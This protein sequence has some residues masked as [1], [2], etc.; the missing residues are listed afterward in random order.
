M[1]EYFGDGDYWTDC[2]AWVTRG[3]WIETKTL[4]SASSFEV[5]SEVYDTGSIRWFSPNIT[6]LPVNTTSDN[7]F[8]TEVKF[9]DDNVTYTSYMSPTAYKARYFQTRVTVTNTA[10]DIT[11]EGVAAIINIPNYDTV[12]VP[13]TGLDTSTLGGTTSARTYD[14]SDYFSNVLAMTAV[15][16]TGE[17]VLPQLTS[18]TSTATFSLIDL[19]TFSKTAIDDTIN[20]TVTGF[21]KLDTDTS[22]GN[23]TAVI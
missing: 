21:P 4:P 16:T 8:T 17:L 22:T 5:E 11:N 12:T 20:M 14:L 3:A 10:T 1:P 18:T 19:D 6:V 7:T 2:G 23:V 9:S 13:F 15:S